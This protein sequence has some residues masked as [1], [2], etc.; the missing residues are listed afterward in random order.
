MPPHESPENLVSAGIGAQEP[1]RD[2]RAPAGFVTWTA[3]GQPAPVPPWLSDA[4][5]A[6]V[7]IRQ[8]GQPLRLLV[9]GD[10]DVLAIVPRLL[11]SPGV[12]SAVLPATRAPD[13]LRRRAWPT[14]F[15]L[16]VADQ[17]LLQALLKPADDLPWVPTEL[18]RVTDVRTDPESVGLLALTVSPAE[19]ISIVTAHPCVASAVLCAAPEGLPW[20]EVARQLAQLRALTGAVAS[21]VTSEPVELLPADLYAM[22]RSLTHGHTFDVALTH[23]LRRDVVLVGEVAALN[24]SRLP[25]LFA[26]RARQYHLDWERATV[27]PAPAPPPV[28]PPMRG[29]GQPPGPILPETAPPDGQQEQ[30]GQE[31]VGAE[32]EPAPP[33]PRSSPPAAIDS[34]GGL[35]EGAFDSEHGEASTGPHLEAEIEKALASLEEVRLLQATV[36]HSD[37]QF[38]STGTF[39]SLPNIWRMGSNDIQVFLGSREQD[40]LAGGVITNAALGFAEDPELASVSLTVEFVPLE[41][42]GEPQRAELVVPRTGRSPD[43]AFSLELDKQ[44]T[45]VTARVVVLHRNRVLQTLI[46]SG[47]LFKPAALSQRLVLWQDLAALDD[48]RPF[49]RAFVLNHTDTGK[50]VIATFAKGT[51]TTITSTA[52]IEAITGRIRASLIA[53][54]SSKGSVEDQRKTLITLAVEGRSLHGELRGYLGAIDNPQRLQIVTARPS[55]FLP[56]EFVYDREAPDDDAVLC[57]HWIADEDCGAGCFAA[58][59]D[60]SVIC[61]QV[62]WGLSRVI[63]RHYVDATAQ[64]GTTFLVGAAP[65]RSRRTLTVTK[66]VLGTSNKVLPP[67]VSAAAKA[68]GATGGKALEPLAGWTEWEGA[69]KAVNPDLLVLMPHTDPKADTLEIAGKTLVGGRIEP[70]YVVAAADLHPVVLLFGCDTGGFTDNPAGYAARFMRAKAGVV[71]STLTMVKGSQASAM[72]TRLA[73]TL[74][75]VGRTPLPM[76]EVL[77]D[78]RR[79]S[80]RGGLL[81]A[82]SITAYGDADWKV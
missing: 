21:A 42:L 70:R 77:R 38:D 16:G 57:Q 30:Q 69:I 65:K 41:P 26:S 39:P 52:E 80:L 20:D 32:P 33:V 23:G 1:V 63:E 47:E 36:N 74:M 62:F 37:G 31:P 45:A 75:T 55:W 51:S 18:V 60:H 2:P 4:V 82:L 78:F 25:D 53:V 56:L 72:S 66:P 59:D 67:D 22:L 49:D 13:A 35:S 8:S 46:L 73:G 9:E 6:D 58:D 5:D 17:A 15:G 7:P 11:D 24:D 50:P 10:L 79:E 44:T 71:F 43:A 12:G 40:A 34:L 81:A 64:T 28:T 3:N 27:L 54:A 14:V 61:P 76:G 48:R 19:A 68:L 29:P